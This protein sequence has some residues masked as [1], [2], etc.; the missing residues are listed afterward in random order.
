MR[1]ERESVCCRAFLF[2]LTATTANLR[3]AGVGTV[4]TSLGVHR[5][6]PYSTLVLLTEERSKTEY[7]AHTG[8]FAETFFLTAFV[9]PTSIYEIKLITNQEWAELSNKTLNNG[10]ADWELVKDHLNSE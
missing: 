9:P 1:L 5:V 6:P 8:E 2:S 10:K 4:L 3:T 7:L